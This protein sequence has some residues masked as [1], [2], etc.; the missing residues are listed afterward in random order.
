MT[1]SLN[2]GNV[3][4]GDGQPAYIVGEI[5]I[6]HNGDIN[7]AKKL[8]AVAAA[9][10]CNAVKFQ[11]RNP[12]LCVPLSQRDLVRETPWGNITYFQY[13]YKVEFGAD[14]YRE[15][16]K[17][18][19]SLGIAWFAS[20]WDLS[21]VDFLSN[22]DPPC[23][24]IPA[25][26]I[27]D[28]DFLKYVRRQACPI[29]MSTG[30]SSLEQLDHAVEVLG[31][32]NLMLLHCCSAYPAAYEDLNLRLIPFLKNRYDVPVGYSGHET[33]LPSSVA[34]VAIGACV[35]ERHITLDRAMWGSDHAASLE[36]NG[37]NRLVR[38]IRL[39]E[40]SM[41]DG[42]KRILPSE[43]PIIKRLRNI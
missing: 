29:I 4:V 2:I 9:A 17:F 31:K 16:D 25:A 38:D 32:S 1:T 41:G 40:K 3:D 18:C 10:G 21:S 7:I 37:I 23:Y 30:M 33:G 14:E 39:I 35:V 24:K 28:D 22:F 36:P 11:K 8:I 42:T 34:A 26:K 19:R 27:T 43:E 20:P 5:G 13:R 12:E 6:N 15:I